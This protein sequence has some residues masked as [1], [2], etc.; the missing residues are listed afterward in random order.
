[1]FFE[2]DSAGDT[3]WELAVADVLV[4][5]R[6]AVVLN[7]LQAPPSGEEFLSDGNLMLQQHVAVLDLTHS[8]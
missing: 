6:G 2:P 7:V 3:V 8:C 4:G 1:M 5:R